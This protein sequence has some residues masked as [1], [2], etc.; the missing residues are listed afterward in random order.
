MEVRIQGTREEPLFNASDIMTK[1]LGYQ[2]MGDCKPWRRISK[3]PKYSI[4][5]DEAR[6]AAS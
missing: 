4:K 5:Y 2:R 1:I 3:L 6:I